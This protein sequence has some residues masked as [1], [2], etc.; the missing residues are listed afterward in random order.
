NSVGALVRE[1]RMHSEYLPKLKI[2]IPS[3]AR[4]FHQ[5]W[6]GLRKMVVDEKTICEHPMDFVRAMEP[7]LEKDLSDPAINRMFDALGGAL[8]RAA[9]EQWK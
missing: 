8:S 5:Q 6:E 7:V 3:E 4:A 1:Q 9:D 2:E